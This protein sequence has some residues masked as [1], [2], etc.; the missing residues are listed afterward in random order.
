MKERG[1]EKEDRDVIRIIALYSRRKSRMLSTY[2]IRAE[3]SEHLHSNN[4]HSLISRHEET[5]KQLDILHRK[6]AALVNAGESDSESER[7][8]G[9]LVVD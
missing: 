4:A 1:W 5:L 6:C 9:S 3:S 8:L 2:D 7:E